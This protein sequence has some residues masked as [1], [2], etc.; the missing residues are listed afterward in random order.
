MGKGDKDKEEKSEHRV[1]ERNKTGV[2]G[3]EVE[4]GVVKRV[5]RD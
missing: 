1:R 4:R 3:N 5:G 2:E